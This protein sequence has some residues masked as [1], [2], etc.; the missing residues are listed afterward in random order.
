MKDRNVK[1]KIYI[2]TFGC[3]MNVSDSERMKAAL[4]RAGFEFAKDESSA[5]IVL[6]NTCSVRQH[7]EERVWSKVGELQGKKVLG[8]VGCMA[9]Q[10]GEKVFNRAP[11]VDLVCGT[12]RFH[13]IGELLEKVCN[14]MK[15]VDVERKEDD[16]GSN[17]GSNG[18]GQNCTFVPISRGCDNK[19]SYCV[20]PYVRGPERNRPMLE[21][22][23]EIK[24]LGYKEV[25]L[26]GQ[27]V[28]SYRDG[29]YG[30]V[31]LLKELNEVDGIERIRFITSH[32]KDAS[33]DL[34][35]AIRELDKVCEH[36]HLPVQSGS[37]KILEKMN[38]G[39]TREH[40]LG[41]IDRVGKDIAIST[42]I[43]V[44]FPG[45]TEDDFRDTY[46]LMKGIG[47]DSAFIF[48]YS[49]RPGTPAAGLE[50]DV[51]IDVKKERNQCLLKLQ[52]EIGLSKNNL[53]V[54]NVL[55]VF[56]EGISKNNKNRLMGRT[57]TNK[58]VV[59]EG[60]KDL[61]GQLVSVKIVDASPHTLFGGGAG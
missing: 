14:G 16:L 40:Y 47:F 20:V 18:L 59:F 44:G 28:N 53:L 60:S 11:Y 31:D 29:N 23:D 5:D 55:E 6:L 36:L 9:Q 19:C 17:L 4:A 12:Y 13:K 37:N 61:V 10:Y 24:R 35:K 48:K 43:I 15:I 3:Q 45:E 25:T 56:V 27:N 2:R 34:F 32:P 54:G 52:D 26:L 50:D 30:F 58:I 7:A 21:I 49:P 33:I 57:R 39:Y 22:I 1:R 46:D 41:L 51:P 42:D 38:R 8:I